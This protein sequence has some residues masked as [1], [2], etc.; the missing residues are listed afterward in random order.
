MTALS[1]DMVTICSNVEIGNNTFVESGVVFVEKM[2]RRV[3]DE[4]IPSKTFVGKNVSVH[5]K[6][7]IEAGAVLEDNAIVDYGEVIHAN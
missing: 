2:N 6:A 7:I 3:K 4:I 5:S 1:E